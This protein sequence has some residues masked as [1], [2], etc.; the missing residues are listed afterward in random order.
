M[1]TNDMDL[2]REFAATGSDDAFANLVGRHVNLVYSVALR[3]L[4]NA[5]DAEEVTQAVFI[6]L[7]KKAGGLRRETVLSGWLYQTAQ[8]TAAN[9]QR[10]ARRRQQREQDAVM[11]FE[12]Q[13]EPGVSRHRLVPLLEEGMRR[14]GPKERDAVVLHCFE[15]RTV[16][17]V[18][19]ALGVQKAAAQKRVNRATDKLRHFFRR[20][21]VQVSPAALF[22]ALGTQAVQAAPAGLATKVAATAALKGAANSGALL[23]LV[24]TTLNHMAWIK[25]KT[26]LLAGAGGAAG[27]NHGGRGRHPLNPRRRGG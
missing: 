5:Q 22:A 10:A 13:S 14:L 9:W 2:V 6:I 26:A 27:R 3:W 25:V 18:A 23:T 7:A 16:A 4:G 20:R 17:E 8:L 11:Q 24:K 21:N 1:Q 15:N 19:A 12:E